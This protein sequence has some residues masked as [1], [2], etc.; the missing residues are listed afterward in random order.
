MRARIKRVVQRFLLITI[1]SLLLLTLLAYAVDYAIFRYRVATNRQ[2]LGQIT[3]YTYDA[4]P[5]K[6]GKTELIF[7]PP[8]AQT[9]VHALFPHSGYA[10]CWYLQRHSER[11]INF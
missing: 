10:T 9:C 6:N 7:H 8:E 1:S 11:R 4:V 5:Q 3:V 2:P